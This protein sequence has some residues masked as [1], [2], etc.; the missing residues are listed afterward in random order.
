MCPSSQLSLAGLR[1]TLDH[2]VNVISPLRN[3]AA[4]PDVLFQPTAPLRCNGGRD[5]SVCH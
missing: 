4:K 1:E 3:R 5:Y 2:R